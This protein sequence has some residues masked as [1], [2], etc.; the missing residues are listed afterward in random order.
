MTGHRIPIPPL[1]GVG[2]ALMG[3]AF[4]ETLTRGLKL[5]ADE[6]GALV[7]LRCVVHPARLDDTLTEVARRA[8][9]IAAWQAQQPTVG[10]GY[11]ETPRAAALRSVTADVVRGWLG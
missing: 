8:E 10:R 7:Q 9:V 3:S 5:Q 1:V 6:E 4:E 11:V 2:L